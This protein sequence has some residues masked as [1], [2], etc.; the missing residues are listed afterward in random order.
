MN[1]NKKIRV[2]LVS[3][4]SAKKVGGIGTWSKSVVDGFAESDE[5]EL[6]FQNTAFWLKHNAVK[7][8]TAL[9]RLIIGGLDTISI[10]V[11]LFLNC[12]YK[13]PDII[14]YTSS[15]SWAL[16][17]DRIAI[18]IAKTFGIPFVIHWHF[19]RIPAI[20]KENGKEFDSFKKVMGCATASIVIDKMSYDALS[21]AGFK[22]FYYVPN[23]LPDNVFNASKEEAPKQR[24]EGSVLF[25][26]QVLKEKGVYELVQSCTSLPSVKKL[27][28]AGPYAEEI[29]EDLTNIASCR[30]QGSWLR[31]LG[32]I[33]REDVFQ[34]YRMCS[35]FALPSYTEGFP[36]VILEAM[37]FG[38]P[39]VATDVGA[40]P[41][42]VTKSTG[43]LIRA[44]DKD[45]LTNAL[46]R[47]VEDSSL[48]STLGNNARN[49][50]IEHYSTKS[51][52]KQYQDIW[53][54]Y[55]IQ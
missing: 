7:K 30:D 21:N 46:K 11:K 12:L 8:Q 37:A 17:K 39:I 1:N 20:I 40:I 34:Y 4:Y 3:P 49:E 6:L 48:A 43:E 15:A 22:N 5:I 9:R 13:R 29:R 45:G 14:N 2:L 10:L 35:V 18:G 54:R 47:L 32:E 31:F 25:V 52:M 19:G 24:E 42:L 27:L 36:Y 41:Q 26:G 33:K 16:H 23:A 44:R 51:V 38:C 28:I 53:N 55:G 50:V